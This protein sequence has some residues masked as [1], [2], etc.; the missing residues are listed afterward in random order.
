LT[1]LIYPMPRINI[2]VTLPEI[3]YDHSI[4]DLAGY[5]QMI[6]SELTHTQARVDVNDFDFTN[7]VSVFNQI[8]KPS[9]P[10]RLYG[11]RDKFNTEV[12]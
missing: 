6:C 9:A 3:P 12:I 1:Y 8:R 11:R 10:N 5:L 2:E 7:S 4:V